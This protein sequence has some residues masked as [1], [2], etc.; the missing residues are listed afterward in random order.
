MRIDA[1][2]KATGEKI[3]K[4]RIALDLSQTVLAGKVDLSRASIAN[5][6][7][8]VQAIDLPQLFLFAEKLGTRPEALLPEF[9]VDPLDNLSDNVRSL[10]QDLI[11]VA[12]H[13]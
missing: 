10:V 13:G 7:R 2:K 3:K 8:G 4:R 1:I 11:K 12:K 5:I 6:E 9:K